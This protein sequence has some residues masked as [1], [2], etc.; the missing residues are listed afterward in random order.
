MYEFISPTDF[1]SLTGMWKI[2]SFD[3]FIAINF[4]GFNVLDR[5]VLFVSWLHGVCI[6]C[7]V[8]G[9]SYQ[10]RKAGLDILHVLYET[11]LYTDNPHHTI[12]RGPGNIS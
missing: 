12:S 4:L 2:R 10:R 7:L 8:P 1:E 11:L 5:S 3:F 9:A 6:D